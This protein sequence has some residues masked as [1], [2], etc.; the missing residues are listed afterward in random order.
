MISYTCLPANPSGE[1]ILLFAI[2]HKPHIAKEKQYKHTITQNNK[3]VQKQIG[4]IRNYFL[5]KNA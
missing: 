1:M 3:S 2:N 5:G 4:I